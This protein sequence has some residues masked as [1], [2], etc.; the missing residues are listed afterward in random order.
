MFRLFRSCSF[1]LLLLVRVNLAAFN[2]PTGYYANTVQKNAAGTWCYFPA[3]G[4]TRSTTC[5]GDFN[6]ILGVH[7][8]TKVAI[9][10]YAPDNT[11]LG[12]PEWSVPVDN[13]GKVTL[14]VSGLAQDTT[15]QTACSLQQIIPYLLVPVVWWLWHKTDGCYPPQRAV[16]K[17]SSSTSIPPST[18][19]SSSTEAQLPTSSLPALSSSTSSSA[20][21]STASIPSATTTAAPTAT[22]QTDGK[23]G[24]NTSDE[25][26]IIFGVITT[27]VGIWGVWVALRKYR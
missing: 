25:I 12:G 22:S 14:C 8:G 26:A 19:T 5:G 24:L 1:Q 16:V 11:R 20:H 17:G 18:T 27:V 10:Y 23:K 3:A 2:L 4:V 9:G 21:R 7:L 6:A 13:A 15:Y